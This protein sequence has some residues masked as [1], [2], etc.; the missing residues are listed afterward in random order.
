MTHSP[1]VEPS[2]G[3]GRVQQDHGL[4][5]LPLRRASA[6]GSRARGPLTPLPENLG[7]EASEAERHMARGCWAGVELDAA[8]LAG[9]TA[10]GWDVGVLAAASGLVIIDCDVKHVDGNGWTVTGGV[11]VREQ[12]VVKRGI[13][14]LRRE[15]EALGHTMAELATYTVRT[16]SGGYHLYY[17][18][19]PEFPLT[20]RHHRQDWR[21]DVI[22]SPNSWVA[23]PPTEGYQVVRDDAVADLPDW[24]AV[25]L[26][27]V[28]TSLAPLG[29][30]EAV[31]ARAVGSGPDGGP[32]RPGESLLAR[33][34]RMLLEEVA[35]ANLAGGW[36]N[37]IYR[38]TH[39]LIEV[40]YDERDVR[41]AVMGAAAPVDAGEERKADATI[42]SALR[43]HQRG[44]GNGRWQG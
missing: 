21:V 6:D 4:R 12:A 37:A 16:K 29:A 43:G 19:N 26:Y 22:A 1:A 8:G 27:G 2:T 41:D 18:T 25:F 9:V 5:Y 30:R 40:G 34:R 44:S 33:H 42:A 31:V 17:R 36:N 38:V 39:A 28:N 35:L 20:S 24:L 23:A 10:A 32:A 7:P 14:D 15:V 11:A 3:S 13:D